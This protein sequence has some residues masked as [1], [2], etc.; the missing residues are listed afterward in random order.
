MPPLTG[1]TRPVVEY[2]PD[3]PS[4]SELRLLGAVE[5][6]RVLDL[7]CGA[8]L[9]A[10]AL[11]RQGAH[12]IAVDPEAGELRRARDACAAAGV[13]VELHLGDLADLAFVRADSVDVTL[14]TYALGYEADLGRLFR[15]VHRVLR[16]RG[17]FVISLIHPA[18][19]LIDPDHPSE[20]LTLRRSYF[21]RAPVVGWD[22]GA[23]AGHHHTLSDLF[24]GLTR[25]NFRV[26]VM[27][28]PPAPAEGVRSPWWRE[29]SLWLPHTL[30]IRARK[31]GG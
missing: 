20:P 5:G 30:V 11:A 19:A 16:P 12:V 18:F 6:R 25:S 4:E 10:I 31:E 29:A 8:G 28:E 1:A 15:Q 23:G 21:D 2:G 27:A 24:T 26:D 22:P 3:V 14:S 13:A 17:A 9:N 7:G